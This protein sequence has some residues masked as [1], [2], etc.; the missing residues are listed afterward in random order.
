MRWLKIKQQSLQSELVGLE[1]EM[2][3]DAKIMK[4]EGLVELS[5]EWQK[6]RVAN[7]KSTYVDF[8]D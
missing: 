3:S 1:A 8:L 6:F 5:T 7:D 2:L 4:N